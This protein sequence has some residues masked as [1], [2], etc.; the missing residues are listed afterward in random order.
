MKL[1]SEKENTEYC[2]ALA[3]ELKGLKSKKDVRMI[4]CPS[5]PFLGD[6]KKKLPKSVA[7]GVQDVH[8]EDRGAYTGE[9][10]PAS[11]SDFGISYAIVG[12]SER[13]EFFGETDDIIAKK[14][15]ACLRNTLQPILCVGE[16]AAER[17]TGKTFAV[18]RRQIESVCAG[19]SP[20]A[21]R[22]VI[23]AY[24]PRWAIGA[25]HT[26]SSNEILEV[27]IA[28]RRTVV[29]LFD[30]ESADA[31]PILYGGSVSAGRAEDIFHTSGLSGVLIG[32]EGLVP[33]EIVKIAS[34]LLKEGKKSE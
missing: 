24:E 9:V 2:A 1:V 7:L 8:W 27:L 29:E 18:I 5:F 11:L 25:D 22:R 23:I 28:I 26:P 21:F 17:A 15:T 3:E 4:L 32:R 33:R 10:S 6:F 13:R 34:L 31:L 20:E 12:H 19:L 16:T 14:L 30:R